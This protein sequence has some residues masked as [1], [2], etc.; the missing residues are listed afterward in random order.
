MG[1]WKVIPKGNDD[2][3]LWIKDENICQSIFIDSEGEINYTKFIDGKV[4]ES[5]TITGNVFRDMNQAE[6]LKD[7]GCYDLTYSDEVGDDS[8]GWY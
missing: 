3:V 1:K 4:K 5:Y 6:M 2:Y 8:F 7:A